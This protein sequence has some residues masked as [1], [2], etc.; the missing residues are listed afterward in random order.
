MGLNIAMTRR[1]FPPIRLRSAT[2]GL[3]FLSLLAMPAAAQ[4]LLSNDSRVRVAVQEGPNLTAVNGVD[5]YTVFVPPGATSLVVELQTTPGTPVELMVRNGVDVGLDPASGKPTISPDRADHWAMPN[6]LG[7]ARVT[8][9]PTDHPPI[10]PGTYNIGFFRRAEDLA[11]DGFLSVSVSGG[12]VESL[13]PVVESKFDSGD[14]GWNRS[15]TGGGVPGGNVGDS[16]SQFF[17]FD[18]RGNPGGFVAVRDSAFGKDEFFVAPDKFLVNLLELDDPRIE[19]DIARLTGLADPNHHIEVRVFN[20]DGGVVWNGHPPPPVP[21]EFDFWTQSVPPIWMHVSAPLRQD[22]WRKL[23]DDARWIDIMSAPK[24]IEIRSTFTFYGG[25]SGLDN[26]QITT[27]GQRPAVDVLPTITG[28]AA[29]YDDWTRNYPADLSI[30]GATVGDASSTLLWA[31]DEGNPSG[32]LVLSETGDTGG[33]R[34]DAYVAPQEFLGIYSNLTNARFEFDYRHESLSKAT[35]PVRIW[36]FGAGSVYRWDGAPPVELWGRQVAPITESAWVRESGSADFAGV[37]A[38]VVRIEVSAE[39]AEGRERNSLDNFALLT[40]DTPPLPQSVT[41]LPRALSFSAVATEGSPEAQTVRISASGPPAHWAA[42]AIGDIADR[43]HLSETEGTPSSE[44]EVSIDT[45]GLAAGSYA[46]QIHVSLQGT[47]VLPE[48]IQGSLRVSDQ[49][50]PT[51]QI[52]QGSVVNAASGQ[53][54]LA[55]GALA[56]VRGTNMGGPEGGVRS[57]YVGHRGDQL[58]TELEGVKVLVY[59]T[60]GGLIAEAPIVSV[61]DTEVEFQMPFEAAGRAEVRV[62]VAIG[63]ARSPQ[64]AVPLTPSAPGVFTT[65]TGHGAAINAD[66]SANSPANPH[67]RLAPMTVYLTGQGRVA[68]DWANGRAAGVSPTIYSPAKAR[69]FIAGQEAKVTFL[70]LAPGMVGVAQMI[71]E[72]NYFTPTGDQPLVVQLNGHQ[73]LPVMVTIR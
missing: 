28:F 47:T 55:A 38:N 5:G 18:E 12:P 58:P 65:E 44:I 3:L 29:G 73:S 43:V 32:R 31:E 24:R 62:V 49:P 35:K 68:P 11:F 54:V 57:G 13:Y 30:P 10:K 22:L 39:H 34:D 36:I 42:E 69:A 14:E 56:V 26:V 8:V 15:V 23:N 25:T 41:A 72:P 63:G 67:P 53:P 61:S 1:Q 6:H 7:L 37:L 64:V 19:F 40:G 52:S 17:Y 66:G 71:L 4:T 45:E 48:V 50:R 21:S 70:A 51:P 2:T 27:R 33:P 46:F 16:D 59:E 9:G 60:W 20:E